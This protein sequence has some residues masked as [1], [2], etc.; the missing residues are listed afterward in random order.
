MHPAVRVFGTLLRLVGI[1]S[2][3][4][5]EPHA[6]PQA[7]TQKPASG[8]PS[9]RSSIASSAPPASPPSPPEAGKPKPPGA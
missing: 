3:E 4:D 8:P 7:A 6:A 1:S 9:W 2:P 5:I